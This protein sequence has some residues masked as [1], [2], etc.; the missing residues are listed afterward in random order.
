[1]LVFGTEAAVGIWNAIEQKVMT[2]IK[3]VPLPS[4]WHLPSEAVTMAL[5]LLLLQY[6]TNPPQSVDALLQPQLACRDP[7]MV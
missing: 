3:V 6:G 2:K 1:M 7:S 4:W 5:A